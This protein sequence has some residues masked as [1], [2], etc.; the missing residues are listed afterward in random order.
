M[1]RFH[2]LVPFAAAT[3]VFGSLAWWTWSAQQE[4]LAVS[5]AAAAANSGR[6]PRPIAEVTSAIA[7]MKLVTVEIDTVV[8]VE[9]GEE[10]WRGNVLA[11]V[12]VPVRLSYGVDLS[13]LEVSKLAWSPATRSYI[14]TVPPPMRVA[15][16]IFSERAP[17]DVQVGWLR[18]RSQAGEYFLSQAR[19]D[20]PAAAA[21]VELLPADAIRVEE[22]T[23]TQLAALVRTIVGGDGGGP[24][25]GVVIRFSALPEEGG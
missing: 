12:Q 2:L 24:D 18:L 10:S 16:Q 1:A 8:R 9:R 14:L 11:K 19:R 20:A 3:C 15:T 22:T 17:P 13:K 25:V 7:V 6:P 5:R 23:R 21:D 4:Q